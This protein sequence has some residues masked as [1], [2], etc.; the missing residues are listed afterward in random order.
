M[1]M[2][3]KQQKLQRKKN[4]TQQKLQRK[5]QRKI[6]WKLKRKVKMP[7]AIFVGILFLSCFYTE[8]TNASSGNIT[9]KFSE[10]V[11][12][13]ILYF[14]VATMFNGEWQLDEE[15]ENCRVDLN[16]VSNGEQLA[17]TAETLENYAHENQIALTENRTNDLE[18]NVCLTQLEEGLYLVV[19]EENDRVI[20]SPT[21]V[22]LPGW[23]GEE[24]SYDVT[25]VPKIAEKNIAPKTGW[26][27][28]EGM[29]A[30]VAGTAFAIIV[31]GL[32][33]KR[34]GCS[35]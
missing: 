34:H 21:L 7:I 32:K 18:N 31:L 9:V 15:F 20:M 13:K 3:R 2:T 23:T 6:R 12:S 22:A 35:K 26:N 16:K 25:V 29:Y 11:D 4:R 10:G 30:G 27:S 28:R 8:I 19:M 1:K 33:G 5:L 17:E 24:M 14:K